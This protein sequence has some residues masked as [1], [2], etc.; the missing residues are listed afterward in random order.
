MTHY[1]T[2]V[3]KEVHEVDLSLSC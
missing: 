2:L 3:C 1:Y